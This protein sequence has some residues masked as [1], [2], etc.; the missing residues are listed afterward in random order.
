MCVF[1]GD[2]LTARPMHFILTQ[3]QTSL[4]LASVLLHCLLLILQLYLAQL[5]L[6]FVFL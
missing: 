1:F 3:A 4:D 5:L 2:D 6:F